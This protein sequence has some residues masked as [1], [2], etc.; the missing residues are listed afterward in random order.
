[1]RCFPMEPKQVNFRVS[2]EKPPDTA[3]M[4]FANRS[5]IL[6]SELHHQLWTNV[7]FVRKLYSWLRVG[8]SSLPRSQSMFKKNAEYPSITT[9]THQQI[10]Q[11]L[12]GYE[13]LYFIHR[14]IFVIKSQYNNSR[15]LNHGKGFLNPLSWCF[16]NEKPL[17]TYQTPTNVHVL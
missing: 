10:Q 3:T 7:P 2:W 8:N 9:K 13:L 12:Q 14:G 17:Q 15:M 16:C 5:L 1:M 4:G 11:Q 6:S